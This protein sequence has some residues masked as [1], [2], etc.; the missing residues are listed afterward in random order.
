MKLNSILLICALFLS[1]RAWLPPPSAELGRPLLEIDTS[2]EPGDSVPSGTQDAQEIQ[3]AGSNP[4]GGDRLSVNENTAR[5][6]RPAIEVDN[7]GEDNEPKTSVL[8]IEL[9]PEYQDA[10]SQQSTN[11]DSDQ[12]TSNDNQVQSNNL[13]PPYQVRLDG[14]GVPTAIKIEID[15]VNLDGGTRDGFFR[16]TRGIVKPQSKH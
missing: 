2:D 16:G 14:N 4:N 15:P 1:V 11:N 8:K 9:D 5:A 10:N 3:Q 12:Q 6:V 7:P 13:P